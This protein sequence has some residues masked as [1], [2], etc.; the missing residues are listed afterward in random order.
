MAFRNIVPHD[1]DMN[2]EVERNEGKHS[3]SDPSIWSEVIVLPDKC[4]SLSKHIIL[5]FF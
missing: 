3:L 4:Y 1:G 2:G 5:S